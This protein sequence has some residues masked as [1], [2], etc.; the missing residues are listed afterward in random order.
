MIVL[1]GLRKAGFY[2]L[3]LE[4][5]D[6]SR[7]ADV[8]CD[9]HVLVPDGQPL[10]RRPF[11][12]NLAWKI[13]PEETR[14]A[15][16]ESDVLAESSAWKR[17]LGRLGDVAVVSPYEAFYKTTRD[18]A[19]RFYASDGQGEL[20]DL[21]RDVRPHG[22]G[23]PASLCGGAVLMTREAWT[24][25]GGWDENVRWLGG[26][27]VIQA[28]KIQ[29]LGVSHELLPYTAYHLFH[30]RPTSPDARKRRDE[31]ETYARSWAK[32]RPHQVRERIAQNN[33][34]LTP[35]EG[36]IHWIRR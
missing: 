7:A 13:F 32:L 19:A 5:D 36:E 20:E 6:T 22:R 11:L 24:Q 10:F 27:D 3:L 14:M 17:A 12:L 8:P 29:A 23:R 15:V 33:H 34:A 28:R 4:Q 18:A 9:G 26:D 16:C 1:E 35:I 31:N 30:E 2:V 21:R 25:L